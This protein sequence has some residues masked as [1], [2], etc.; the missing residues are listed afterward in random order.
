[1]NSAVF[2]IVQLAA[3]MSLA[4]MTGCSCSKCIRNKRFKLYN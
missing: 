1:M 4:V 3:V 2:S